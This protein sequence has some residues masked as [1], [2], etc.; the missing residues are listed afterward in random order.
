M[1]GLNENASVKVRAALLGVFLFAVACFAVCFT[2]SCNSRKAGVSQEPSTAPNTPQTVAIE[3][4]VADAKAYAPP[5]DVTA[6]PKF[7]PDVFELLREEFIRAIEERERRFYGAPDSRSLGRIPSAAPTGDA[8][9][10]T[11]LT[12]D[13]T[14]RLNWSYVNIGDYDSSGEVGIPDI[15]MIAQNYLAKS[16]DGIGDDALEAWIDG[17][18]SGEVGV[19]DIT[20]IAQGYLNT[21]VAYRIL[22]SSQPDS[23]F[24]AIGPD[25]PFG[26]P[27]VFPKTFSVLLPAGVQQYVAVAPVAGGNQAGEFSESIPISLQIGAADVLAVTP[28]NCFEGVPFDIWATVNGLP[29]LVYSWDFGTSFAPSTSSEASPSITCNATGEFDCTLTVANDLGADVFNFTISSSVPAMPPI[30]ESVT[31][32][33]GNAGAS[34]VFSANIAGS[35]PLAYQWSFG[36]GATPNTSTEESPMAILNAKGTYASSLTVSNAYGSDTFDFE[37]NVLSWHIETLDSTGDVGLSTSIALD[38]NG[39]PHIS[40]G[41]YTNNSLKYTYYNASS[42][43]VQTVDSGNDAGWDTS[44]ALDSNNRPHISY[45]D[46]TTKDLKYAYYNDTLWDIAIVDHQGTVGSY[47][48]IALDSQDRAHITYCDYNNYDLKYASFN[49]SSWDIVTIDSAGAVGQYSSLA[50]NMVD[51]PNISYW[52]QTNGSLKYAYYNGLTWSIM[53]V[54]GSEAVGQYSSLALDS[55]DRPHISYWDYGNNDLKYSSYNGS[56]WDIATIDSDGDVGSFSSLIL[57]SSNRAHI[58]YYN[59][60]EGDLKYAYYDGTQWITTVL[61]PDGGGYYTSMAIDS[62]N[63]LHISYLDVFNL[64]LKYVMLE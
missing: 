26:D 37:L 24:A 15:T 20:A 14:G 29:P 28:L 19:P 34:V 54:D 60:W 27:N 63:R 44:I 42:W 57:D 11:D 18:K 21:V 30:I 9:R 41:D 36:G 61:D 64:D 31:P 7:D 13:D 62:T 48:S 23:G 2:L 16:N 45:L 56:S 50:F 17:D 1:A 35:A 59:F 8:G 25:I 3:Q 4:V 53:I 43:I 52:D 40:Y 32:E 47:T 38:S 49:S 10:V 12:Y 46:E 51:C 22:T 55:Y 58:S 39:L 33:T 5:A 6:D